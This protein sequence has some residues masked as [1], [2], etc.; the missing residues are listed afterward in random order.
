MES[1]ICKSSNKKK[2]QKREG[3][4]CDHHKFQFP[5]A[6]RPSVRVHFEGIADKEEEGE[7]EEEDEDNDDEKRVRESEKA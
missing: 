6:V 1:V 5:L 7:E 4:I 3:W 2:I